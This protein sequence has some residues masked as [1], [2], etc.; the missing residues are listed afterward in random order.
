[1]NMRSVCA[2]PHD[3]RLSGKVTAPALAQAIATVVLAITDGASDHATTAL[4]AATLATAVLGWS[5]VD[6]RFSALRELALAHAAWMKAL[7]GDGWDGSTAGEQWNSKKGDA[8]PAYVVLMNWT[9]EGAH[10]FRDTVDLTSDLESRIK[11]FGGTLKDTFWTLGA[12]DGLVLFDAPD[13]ETASAVALATG[14]GGGVRTTTLRAF[15][16]SEMEQIVE[17]AR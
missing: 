11:S 16:R 12:Y 14:E 9:N 15:E 5:K 13:D 17:K 6:H 8:M 1:M 2:T 4:A 7:D 3:Q 10:N